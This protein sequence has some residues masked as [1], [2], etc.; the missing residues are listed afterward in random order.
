MGSPELDSA[1][2]QEA[3]VVHKMAEEVVMVVEKGYKHY[4]DEVVEVVE[5]G[6]AWLNMG[7]FRPMQYMDEG[8]VV[9]LENHRQ[10]LQALVD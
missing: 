2:N 8:F 5:L 10:K 3:L 6:L 1:K 7:L 9:E 4:I